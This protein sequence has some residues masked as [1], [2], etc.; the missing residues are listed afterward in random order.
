MSIIGGPISVLLIAA[1]L[2]AAVVGWLLR[3]R[4]HRLDPRRAADQD[5]IDREELDVAERE[6]RDLDLRQRPED[7]FEGDDWGLGIARRPRSPPEL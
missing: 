1:A 4:R 5:D 6:V 3:G 7:G 2:T